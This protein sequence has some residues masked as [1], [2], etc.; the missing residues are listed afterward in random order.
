VVRRIAAESFHLQQFPSLSLKDLPRLIALKA[1]SDDAYRIDDEDR[2]E[3]ADA[4]L[5]HHS[6]FFPLSRQTILFGPQSGFIWHTAGTCDSSRLVQFSPQESPQRSAFGHEG[7]SFPNDGPEFFPLFTVGA[8]M[9]RVCS[10][11]PQWG[12]TTS[13]ITSRTL[14]KTSYVSLHELHL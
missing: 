2:R 5:G 1:R 4:A 13:S 9:R 6:A 14:W 7:I 12:Q 3:K 8:E 11:E 10:T